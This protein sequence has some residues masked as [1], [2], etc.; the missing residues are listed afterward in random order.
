MV[1]VSRIAVPIRPERRRPA[2]TG[3]AVALAVV[4]MM[5]V[6]AGITVAAAGPAAAA[7]KVG[8]GSYTTDP[9]GPLPSG[10][11]TIS[12]NPRQFLTEN[13][14]AGAVPTN[15]WW[16]S[17]A[18][19]KLN[20]QYSEILQAHPAAYLPNAGGLGFSYST[21]PRVCGPRS[22]T[23]GISLP[24]SPGFHRRRHRAECADGQGR[25]LVR[26]DRHPV[27][28]RRVPLDDGHDRPR[29][30]DDVLQGHRW[31]RATHR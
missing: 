18:F 26:L 4:T 12:T 11:G 30:A 20:C 2:R 9:V 7:T 23:A 25:R 8:N 13:A 22:G 10:C 3:G 15:D 14:P 31:W 29:P 1:A 24:L 27:L 16:S 21:S 28:G 6:V 19:K 5:V 17:L